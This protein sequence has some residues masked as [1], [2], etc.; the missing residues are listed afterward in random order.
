MNQEIETSEETVVVTDKDARNWGMIC[1]LAGLAGFVV[2][3][4][5]VLGPL[6][7]WAIKKDDHAFVDDQGKEALNFQLTVALAV[8]IAAF[9][10]LALVGLVLIPL[11]VIYTL[12]MVIIAAIKAN[13]GIYYR[14][15][16]TFRFFK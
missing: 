1:H 10:I 9:L 7:V 11:V 8:I 16:L 3:F 5:N 4:G 6:I 14:Y 12:I 15:P 13:D 2:P